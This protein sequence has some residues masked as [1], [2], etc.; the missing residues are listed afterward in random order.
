MTSKEKSTKGVDIPTR[1]VIFR[2]PSE[3][4]ADYGTTPG[5]TIFS[6]TPGG[7]VWFLFLHS[8]VE[9]CIDWTISCHAGTRIVYDRKSLLEMRNSPLSRTP[10]RNLPRIPG[11]TAVGGVNNSPAAKAPVSPPPLIRE[12]AEGT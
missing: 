5:G 9:E 1:K 11:V 10:P 2:D 7:N 3:L 12:T 4:P 6:T 8:F